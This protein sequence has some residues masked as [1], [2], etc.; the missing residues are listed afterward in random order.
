MVLGQRRIVSEPARIMTPVP[1]KI[2]YAKLSTPAQQRQGDFCL[3][4]MARSV[5]E[6]ADDRTLAGTGVVA[7]ADT[8]QM[9][10]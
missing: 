1:L 4:A 5:R 3:Q 6:E 8:S 10:W 9:C 2:T 7:M